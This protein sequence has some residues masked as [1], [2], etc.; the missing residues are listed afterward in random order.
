MAKNKADQAKIQEAI[1]KEEKPKSAF[2]FAPSSTNGDGESK[3]AFSF[4]IAKEQ[5]EKEK[6]EK[7]EKKE[8]KEET[9]SPIASAPVTLASI[10]PAPAVKPLGASIATS[11][12]KSKAFG[13]VEELKLSD[14]EKEK[15]KESIPSSPPPLQRAAANELGE[16]A[17]SF[18]SLATT[19]PTK[20]K[21]KKKKGETTAHLQRLQKRRK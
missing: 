10:A 6:G 7:E 12:P 15:Q 18:G 16:S 21:K 20:K 13:S 2:S 5:S 19:A 3:S 8:K 4:G 11:V 1:E 17:F 14:N 9:T